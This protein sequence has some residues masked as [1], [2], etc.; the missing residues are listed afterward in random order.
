MTK[1]RETII[2]WTPGTDLVAS[3]PFH[4]P[5]GWSDSYEYTGGAAFADV[6]EMS[7]QVVRQYLL[8]LF[9]TMVIRD[10]VDPSAAHDALC[11]IDE[12]ATSINLECPGAKE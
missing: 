3:G 2:A 4:A 10:R 7:D 8:N 5:G 1:A 9:H 6:R 11:W 12:F